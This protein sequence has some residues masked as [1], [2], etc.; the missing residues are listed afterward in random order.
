MTTTAG[1]RRGKAREAGAVTAEFAIVL[2]AVVV[3]LVL[4]LTV[5][6][7]GVTRLQCT[8]AARAATRAAA[9]GQGREEIVQIAEASASAASVA[10]ED[11]AAWVS[12]T[13]TCPVDFALFAGPW[14]VYSTFTTPSEP[15]GRA[16]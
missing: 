3:A 9:L 2:P 12:V 16:P 1:T 4:V 14:S 6:A 8:D 5:L 7:A 11:D 13:V 15:D 10:I